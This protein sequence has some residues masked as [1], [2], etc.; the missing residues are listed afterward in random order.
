MTHQTGN[1]DPDA[2]SAVERFVYET[3]GNHRQPKQ[4]LDGIELCT[5]R[6]DLVHVVGPS[7]SGKTSL[8]RLINGLDEPSTGSTKVLG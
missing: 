6:G 8:I 3:S 5:K 7:G 2:D 1:Y 4:I